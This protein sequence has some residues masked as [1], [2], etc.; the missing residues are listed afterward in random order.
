MEILSYI[1]ADTISRSPRPYDGYVQWKQE[2][3]YLLYFTEKY[4][5]F[6][7]AN[8]VGKTGSGYNPVIKESNKER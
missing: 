5:Y 3:S 1:L 6:N 2:S 8:A 4:S 7:T